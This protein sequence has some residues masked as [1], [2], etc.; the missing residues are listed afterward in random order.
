MKVA[1]CSWAP[2]LAGA[3]VAAERLGL[4]L[5]MAGCD[6]LM[7]V[8]T[9]GAAHERFRDAGLRCELVPMYTTDKWKP[10]LSERMNFQLKRIFRRERPNIVYANDLPTG[11][12]VG[13]AARRRG[14]P[15]VYHHRWVFE[16]PAID[17]L[18]KYGA[19][20]HIFVSQY[21]MDE[22]R[23]ESRRLAARPCTV[24]HD[25]LPLP[26]PTSEEDRRASRQTL[27][28]PQ[29]KAIVL[30]AG[31]V[32]ERKGISDALRAWPRATEQFKGAAELH[33][34]GDDLEQGGAYRL[35]ME[36]LAEEIGGEVR[37]HGFRRDVPG[38]LTACDFVL[39][40]S[41]VEPL[42]NATLEAMAHSRPVIASSVGGIPEM[43]VSEATGILH[44]PRD[45]A[46][47]AEAMK[48]LIATPQLRRVL[49]EAGRNRC[50]EMFSLD[51]HVD[52]M[53]N[54]FRVAMGSSVATTA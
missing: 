39:V 27:G 18:N 40:P 16:G 1:L 28:L 45:I 42:G 15:R 50:E 48:R 17:W 7:I 4:G 54:E 13:L 30:L 20:R 41:H 32:I 37:F 43:V 12:M 44:P 2:F 5:Q 23:R 21:L 34:V 10:W 8:G 6:V 19:E 31:Q 46:A 51:Q 53:I 49:G 11:Q 29:E 14:L 35:Q 9:D 47:L 26:P 38:W 33:V 3:E 36:R 52:A 22:L 24:V 25:G